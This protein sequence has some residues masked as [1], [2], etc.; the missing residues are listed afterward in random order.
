MD[1]IY[2]VRGTEQAGPFTEAEIRAQLASGAITGDTMIWWEGLPEWSP[3]SRTP[4]GAPPTTVPAA[5]G[6]VAPT[7]GPATGSRTSTLAI[8]ALVSGILGLI[9][10]PSAIVCGT[11]AIITGH[12]ERKEIKRAPTVSGGGLA[13]A[14]LILGY[15][16]VA[17]FAVA[18]A[19][20]GAAM[21][22]AV[23]EGI[24]NTT[25]GSDTNSAPVQDSDTNSSATNSAPATP[26]Q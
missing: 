12:L 3:L 17:V 9:C 8:V 22:Y 15:V 24:N 14:G 25:Q 5:P 16:A 26:S 13:L 20:Y 10:W 18:I 6:A 21:V 11:A 7:P 1:K 4:L 2:V 23:H 19:I